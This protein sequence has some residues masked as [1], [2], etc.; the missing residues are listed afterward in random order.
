MPLA[1]PDRLSDTPNMDP[2]AAL[3]AQAG[4]SAA[5]LAFERPDPVRFPCLDLAYRALERGGTAPAVLSAANEVAVAAFVAGRLRFGEIAS[6]VAQTLEMLG[7]SIVGPPTL[8]AIRNADA[9]ARRITSERLFESS[10]TTVSNS[11]GV[12]AI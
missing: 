7:E 11:R 2:L 6:A 1:F 8:T 9:E 12:T 10:P 5:V 3:G 4:A